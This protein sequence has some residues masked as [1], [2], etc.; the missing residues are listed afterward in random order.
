MTDKGE[1]SSDVNSGGARN[2]MGISSA[3][4]SWPH[5]CEWTESACGEDREE[6]LR[7]FFVYRAWNAMPCHA[8]PWEKGKMKNI[9]IKCRKKKTIQ[10]KFSLVWWLSL[11]KKKKISR[12]IILDSMF[13]LRDLLYPIYFLFLL[14][15]FILIIFLCNWKKLYP[16]T[17]LHV[18]AFYN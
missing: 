13:L 10:S 16:L 18:G 15:H 12:C 2:H 7:S 4:S 3:R 9:M 17:C 5:R 6:P 11:F 1:R 8:M 14:F